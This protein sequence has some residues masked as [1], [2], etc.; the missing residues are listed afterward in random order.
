MFPVPIFPV[1]AL[2]VVVLSA[3][4]VMAKTFEWKLVPTF[5]TEPRYRLTRF[6]WVDGV[7]TVEAAVKSGMEE[8]YS[9]MA[10]FQSKVLGRDNDF[11]ALAQ[12]A[13]ADLALHPNGRFS[14]DVTD[15]RN[16]Y[17][18]HTVALS[19]PSQSWQA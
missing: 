19:D 15:T 13:K 3:L 7:A 16:D 8:V 10:S 14:Y 5:K 6:Q 12:A 11:D 2:C 17:S 4:V 18:H 1:F 9:R